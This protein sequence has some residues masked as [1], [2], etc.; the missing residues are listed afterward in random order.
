MDGAGNSLETLKRNTIILHSICFGL[1][2]AW[3]VQERVCYERKP[4]A[5][6]Y[7]QKIAPFEIA[8]V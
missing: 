7:T 5:G 8:I 6:A 2:T 3:A 1:I 4:T